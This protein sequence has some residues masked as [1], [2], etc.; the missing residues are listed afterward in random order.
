MTEVPHVIIQVVDGIATVVGKPSGVK[1]TI[2]DWDDEHE[3]PED[4]KLDGA[5]VAEVL[6]PNQSVLNLITAIQG[7]PA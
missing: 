5:E 7:T 1:V 6:T 3:D 4:A 2:V